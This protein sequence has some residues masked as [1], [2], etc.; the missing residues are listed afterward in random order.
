MNRMVWEYL[1]RVDA[2]V[3]KRGDTM[4]RHRVQLQIRP[5]F[6]T[7]PDTNRIECH[8]RRLGRD[9]EVHD[10]RNGSKQGNDAFSDLS[11]PL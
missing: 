7:K 5:S 6:H 8:D 3:H 10:D 9:D 2:V 4:D 11:Y 1:V